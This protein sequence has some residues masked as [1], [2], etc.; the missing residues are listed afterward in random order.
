[1]LRYTQTGVLNSG[2]PSGSAEK[3]VQELVALRRNA[4]VIVNA[5]C[6]VS[7]SRGTAAARRLSW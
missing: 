3:E 1:M 5:D 7:A 4:G 2:I 6:G